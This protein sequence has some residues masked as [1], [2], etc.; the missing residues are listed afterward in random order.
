MSLEE[1][2]LWFRARRIRSDDS[3]C[4]NPSL[5]IFCAFRFLAMISEY[6]SLDKAGGLS[7]KI[8]GNMGLKPKTSCAGENP[9]TFCRAFF[10]LTDH[11]IA[12]ASEQSTS[13][14]TLSIISPRTWLYLSQMSLLQELSAAVVET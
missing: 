4:V 13:L 6:P 9:C 3:A 11:A 10:A 1:Q 14:F 8:L 12:T 7:L 2:R 5:A